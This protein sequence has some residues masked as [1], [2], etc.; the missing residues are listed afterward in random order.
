MLKFDFSTLPFRPLANIHLILIFSYGSDSYDVLKEFFDAWPLPS[1][2][3]IPLM[4]GF[5]NQKNGIKNEN[6]YYEYPNSK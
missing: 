3:F 2:G 6:G 4:Q 5:C 1:A